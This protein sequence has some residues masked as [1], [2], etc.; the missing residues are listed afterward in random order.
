MPNINPTQKQF[1]LYRDLKKFQRKTLNEK[2][3]VPDLGILVKY[4][5][6]GGAKLNFRQLSIFTPNINQI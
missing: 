2:S 5:G 6:W 3:K 1:E 4:M